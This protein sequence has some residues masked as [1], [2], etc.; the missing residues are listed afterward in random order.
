LTPAFKRG[1]NSVAWSP[2]GDEIWFGGS[3][4]GDEWAIYAVDLRGRLRVVTELPFV[5]HVQDLMPD[6]SALVT[7]HYDRGET[8]ARAPGGA[9]EK[10]VSWLDWPHVLDISRDGRQLLFWEFGSGGARSYAVY[11]RP[12]DG[13]EPAVLVGDTVN[14]LG[15]ASF[16]PDP[17]WLFLMRASIPPELRL[18]PTGPGE[19]KSIRPTGVEAQLCPAVHREHFVLS[20]GRRVVFCGH[21]AGR[22]ARSWLQDVGGGRP[23]PITP[24]GQFVEDV[25]P[26]GRVALARNAER[27]LLLYPIEGGPPRVAPGPPETGRIKTWSADSRSLFVAERET[28][29]GLMARIFRRDLATGRRELWKEVRPPDQAGLVYVTMVVSADGSAYAYSLARCLS[30]LYLVEGLK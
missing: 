21:E 4:R 6:G 29:D 2:K 22:P 11:L 15:W 13:S 1:P 18:V 3:F 25:S 30:S 16:S 26:D 10:N 14:S 23:R 27:Q 7:M 9:E 12:T 20:N 8:M 19:S 5:G 24:E 28:S 17:Q